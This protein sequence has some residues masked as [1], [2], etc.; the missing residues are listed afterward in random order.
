[1]E[2]T[3]SINIPNDDM[4]ELVDDQFSIIEEAHYGVSKSQVLKLA[5]HLNLSSRVMASL[6][7]ISERTLSRYKPTDHLKESNSEHFL[8]IKRVAETGEEVFGDLD[9]FLKWLKEPCEALGNKLPIFLLGS[10][11]GTMLVLDEL[12][13]IDYGIPY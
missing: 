2:P 7:R 8:Q 10:I 5:R 6:L 13:R 11:T 4:L 1:M 9:K 3:L 12:V